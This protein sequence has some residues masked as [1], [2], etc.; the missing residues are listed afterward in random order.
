M[1]DLDYLDVEVSYGTRWVSLNDGVTYQI[2]ANDTR[3]SATKSYRRVVAQSM[4]LGGDYLVHAV[5][6]MVNEQVTVWVRGQDQIELAEN[7]ERLE[8]LFEQM[9]FRMRWTYNDYRETW[10]C[11]LPDVSFS[12]GQVWTHNAMA[13]MSFQVP[14]YP[15]VTRERIE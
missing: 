7:L 5:P 6:N 1:S 2:S 10:V 15:D 3:D 8:E 9:D 13:I 4:V 12:R 14:R 11:Q